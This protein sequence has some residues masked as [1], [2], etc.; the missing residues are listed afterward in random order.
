MISHPV[1]G[2]SCRAGTTASG[3]VEVAGD[4]GELPATTRDGGGDYQAPWRRRPPPASDLGDQKFGVTNPGARARGWVRQGMSAKQLEARRRGGVGAWADSR[5]R[6]GM[7]G[8]GRT[9]TG[10]QD[11]AGKGSWAA[12]ETVTQRRL[13][14]SSG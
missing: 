7:L 10:K 3:D 11:G 12:R 2:K 8:A 6:L 14:G 5:R 9:P 13:Q 4:G 1:V